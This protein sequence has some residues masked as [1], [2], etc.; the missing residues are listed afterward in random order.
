[1]H[2]SSCNKKKELIDGGDYEKDKHQHPEMRKKQDPALRKKSKK[3]DPA[4]RKKSKKQDPALR[5]KYKKQI[6]NG[7]R[8]PYGSLKRQRRKA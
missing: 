6:P 2:V 1:V 3:Q 5:K 4:L 7:S 8:R